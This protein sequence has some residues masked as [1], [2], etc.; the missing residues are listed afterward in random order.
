M[1]EI[2]FSF[3][4][5]KEVIKCD[6]NEKMEDI[7][8]KIA[9]KINK[10][11]NIIYFIYDHRILNSSESRTFL[12]IA[13]DSDKKYKKIYLLV[14]KH[15][16]PFDFLTN[17]NGD[18]LV[19]FLRGCDLSFLSKDDFRRKN[20]IQPFPRLVIC[21]S[22]EFDFEKAF[23]SKLELSEKVEKEILLLFSAYF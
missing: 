14:K 2:V 7:F 21:P 1:V 18:P 19:I 16:D 11:I 17:N 4:N 8:Q 20:N 10:D 6:V 13:N 12:E 9:T 23:P 22:K 3:E 5:I 15:F